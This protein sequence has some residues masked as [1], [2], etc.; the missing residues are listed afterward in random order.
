MKIIVASDSH[1]ERVM[2][3]N[4]AQEINRR[5]DV[6][7]VIHLGDMVGDADW[8]RRSLPQPV[9]SVPG[10][11]DMQFGPSAEQVVTLGGVTMLLCH[12]HTHRVKYA[13]EPLSY[14]AEAVGASVAL[15]GHTHARCVQNLGGVLL[16][17]P[18]ALKD[19]RYALLEIENGGVR[20]PQ[21]L[22]L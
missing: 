7:A 4:L 11:C 15:F 14:H 10:N 5:G 2:L 6:D 17:N 1:Y 3:M 13:L 12:G 8:L 20:P 18:G 22:T 16:V 19:G 21:M 9:Y